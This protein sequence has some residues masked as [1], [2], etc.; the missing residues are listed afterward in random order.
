MTLRKVSSPTSRAK[1]TIRTLSLAIVLGMGSG[2]AAGSW[3]AASL[4]ASTLLLGRP[5]IAADDALEVA[6]VTAAILLASAD[7]SFFGHAIAT[8]ARDEPIDRGVTTAG[9]IVTGP[10]ALSFEIA[11]AMVATERDG[12]EILAVM[13]PWGMI[14]NSVFV[15]AVW[16]NARPEH[17]PREIFA[18]ASVIGVNAGWTSVLIGY[19][20]EPAMDMKPIGLAM[21]VTSGINLGVSLPMALRRPGFRGGWIGMSGWSG[22]LFAM[23]LAGAVGAWT[24][25]EEDPR[26]PHHAGSSRVY[27]GPIGVEPIVA[28][29]PAGALGLHGHW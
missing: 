12:S 26:G 17:S 29:D 8:A 21:A 3:L 6:S 18:A 9:A 22:A 2:R 20:A 24:P 11:M 7:L 23:G 19:A 1:G 15:H 14:T 25:T 16:S 27:V 4:S 28:G 13:A 5:A 10:Q